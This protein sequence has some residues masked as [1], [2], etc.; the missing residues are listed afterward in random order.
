MIETVYKCDV[1]GTVR[2]PENH[3][4]LADE[5]SRS[6]V[7]ILV[8]WDDYAPDADKHLCGAVCA[9][10]ILDRYLESLRNGEGQ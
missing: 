6:G 9:H 1:C 2:G 5:S 8:P 3:W 10:K 7:F 4:L